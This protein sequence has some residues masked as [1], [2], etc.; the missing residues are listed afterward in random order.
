[1]PGIFFTQDGMI[2]R[3]APVN[4]KAGIK[5]ADA[6]VGFGVIK[7]VTFVLEDGFRTQDGKSVGKAAG[8]EELAVVVFCQF[9]CH[10]LA[11]SGTSFADVNGHIQYSALHAAYQFALG[12]RGT[13]E[14]Q[15]AHDSVAGFAFIVLYK[16]NFSYFTVEILLRI[17][18]EEITA[19]IL[20]QTRLDNDHA[21]NLCGNYFHNLLKVQI[22]FSGTFYLIDHADQVFAVL[23][24]QHGLCKFA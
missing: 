7:V 23:V 6:A 14:M 9:D 18:F 13:L 24:F 21:F 5:D 11:I 10:M 8:N 1:M 17:R 12:E 16:M 20:K 15:S 19:V 2:S 22:T 3:Y 4:A